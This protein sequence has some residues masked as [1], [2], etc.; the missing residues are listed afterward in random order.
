[1]ATY[2]IGYDLNRPGQDYPALIDAIKR[3][4]TWWHHLDSTWIVV[5][6][7]KAPTKNACIE[8]LLK[9]IGLYMFYIVGLCNCA[10]IVRT[11]ELVPQRPNPLI[12]RRHP[13]TIQ[14]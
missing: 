11:I 12:L 9:T 14:N 1:M 10:H 5:T 6:D 4:G 2:M 13:P 3:L 8:E 7:Q